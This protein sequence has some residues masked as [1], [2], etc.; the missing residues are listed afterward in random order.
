MTTV[1]MRVEGM[2]VVGTGVGREKSPPLRTTHVL[3]IMIGEGI[4]MTVTS[5]HERKGLVE[6]TAVGIGTGTLPR[7]IPRPVDVTAVMSG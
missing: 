4:T 6:G 7:H 5:T 1:M 2:A 3:T